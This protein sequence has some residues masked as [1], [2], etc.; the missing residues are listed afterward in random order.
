[1]LAQRTITPRTA[2]VLANAI[3]LRAHWEY[4]FDV[5]LTH[6]ATFTTANRQSVQAPFMK[7]DG[8]VFDYGAR[9]SYQAID[10]P[11]ASSNLSMLAILPRRSSLAAFDRTLTAGSLAKIVGS[12]T[13]HTVDLQMPTLDLSTQLS[14][15][16]ALQKLGMTDAFK[17]SA[18]FSALTTQRALYIS[19]VAH[20]ADLKID[21][22][23]T[24]ATAATVIIMPMARV[25]PQPTV[26]L[27]L[28]HPYLLLL[29]DDTSGT[30][31]FV[32]QVANPSES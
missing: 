14:L 17:P 21:E 20:A 25:A 13:P 4:S 15:N 7:R 24:V 19:L 28:N 8:T 3:Y 9:P 23:G 2:V 18:S 31:L 30:I 29:R 12:L 11:Y 27:T 1:M 10:L 5:S 16:D 22:Q 32:A 26:T 6:P